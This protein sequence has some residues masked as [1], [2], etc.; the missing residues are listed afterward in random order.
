MAGT[1]DEWPRAAVPR[2]ST[3][4]SLRISETGIEKARGVFR[5]VAKPTGWR[6]RAT[7]AESDESLARRVL[8]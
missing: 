4:G 1:P 6:S 8:H 3:L 5:G 7:A 2:L